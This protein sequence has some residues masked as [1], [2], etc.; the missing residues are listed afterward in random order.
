M[1]NPALGLCSLTKV[2]LENRGCLWAEHF[3]K[4]KSF[5]FVQHLLLLLLKNWLLVICLAL[6]KCI[7]WMIWR[8]KSL[9]KF[10]DKL[11]ELSKYSP[12]VFTVKEDSNSYE[13]LQS[14]RHFSSAWWYFEGVWCGQS[15]RT[16]G[17]NVQVQLKGKF[18]VS[19]V[20]IDKFNNEQLWELNKMVFWTLGFCESWE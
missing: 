1:L 5:S 18:F 16:G 8:K 6:L 4:G 17:N 14:N 10:K 11:N 2:A 13:E 12:V 19:F 20:P 3:G 9:W 7:I 15:I